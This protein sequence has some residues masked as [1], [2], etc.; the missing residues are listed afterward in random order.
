MGLFLLLQRSKTKVVRSIVVGI[1]PRTL[2]QATSHLI[3][4]HRNSTK[5]EFQSCSSS[6][7]QLSFAFYIHIIH[8]YDYILNMEAKLSSFLYFCLQYD[9][10]WSRLHKYIRNGIFQFPHLVYSFRLME[11]FSWG[12]GLSNFLLVQYQ[13]ITKLSDFIL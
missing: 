6:L 12:H 11:T 5:N 9:K 7:A 10:R 13:T 1:H 2:F 8:I 4:S 3:Q